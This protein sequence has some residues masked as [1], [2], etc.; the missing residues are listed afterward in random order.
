[1]AARRSLY[2]STASYGQPIPESPARKQAD[3]NTHAYI[4]AWVNDQ[5]R[6]IS[7][8]ATDITPKL[9]EMGFESRDDLKNMREYTVLMAALGLNYVEANSLANDAMDIHQQLAAPL[10]ATAPLE[11]DDLTIY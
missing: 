5:K 10:A 6:S 4:S 3:I 8:K 9:I 1:M 2:E 7:R 11:A